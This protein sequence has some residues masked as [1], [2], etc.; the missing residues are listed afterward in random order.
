M[1][2]LNKEN[3]EKMWDWTS[4]IK[5]VAK[6]MHQINPIAWPTEQKV[7]NYINKVI[8]EFDVEKFN[9]NIGK[10]EKTW[11]DYS[12]GK[13]ISTGGLKITYYY[14]DDDL[15]EIDI[16]INLLTLGTFD[17]E[18]EIDKYYS[19]LTFKEEDN[20]LQM[21]IMKRDYP[22]IYT[23]YEDDIKL[24]AKQFLASIDSGD[25]ATNKKEEKTMNT[26]TLTDEQLRMALRLAS[27][28]TKAIR[29]RVD[30]VHPHSRAR[31]LREAVL[32]RVLGTDTDRE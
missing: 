2:K 30:A 12:W 18:K 9:Y 3:N 6:I 5:E 10:H 7:E 29:A 11:E 8:D 24:K 4:K 1:L 23:H 16:S 15:E 25:L 13:F 32:E 14:W 22:A 21:P 17:K 19:Y 20:L 28:P 27:R 31:A 26:Y